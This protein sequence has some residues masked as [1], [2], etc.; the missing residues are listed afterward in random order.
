MGNIA[1]M[2]SADQEKYAV[3][4]VCQRTSLDEP[5][6]EQY[7]NQ[8]L[9]RVSSKQDRK[10]LRIDR[11][12]RET[13]GVNNF[14]F[15]LML[16]KFQIVSAARIILAKDSADRRKVNYYL[17]ALNRLNFS[18]DAI[19]PTCLPFETVLAAIG[20]KEIHQDVKVFPILFDQFSFNSTLHRTMLNKRMKMSENLLLEEKMITDSTHVYA[21]QTWKDH[22]LKSFSGFKDHITYAEHPLLVEN[23]CLT[24]I[25]HKNQI[26]IVYTGVIDFH[27]RPM[28][29][30]ATI[31]EEYLEKCKLSVRFHFYVRGNECSLI[32]KLENRYPNNIV[33][34]GSVPEKEAKAAIANANMLLSLGNTE[35]NQFPSK[36]FDY[37][38]CGIPIIHFYILENDPVIN[39]L[40]KYPLAICLSQNKM[41]RKDVL[42]SF[43]QFVVDFK[44]KRIPF[45]DITAVFPEATPTFITGDILNRL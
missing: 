40:K 31:I 45:E 8:D 25:C 38:S 27:I 32:K 43:S 35:A 36:I 28:S 44:D 20:Y 37:I 15:R 5:D 26:S 6:C 33:N 41:E 7:K 19:I 34:H 11:E 42:S 16:R 1:E 30:V 13:T 39:I 12:I 22:L 23:N 21:M 14:F 2:F 29:I 18:V 10:R 17:Q 24:E 9:I 3:T 4:V